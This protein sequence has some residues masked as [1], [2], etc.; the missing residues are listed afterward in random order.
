MTNTLWTPQNPEQTLLMDYMKSV[1]KDDMTYPE[2]WSWSCEH[3]DE[4]WS[5]LWDFCDVIGDKGSRVLVE[6]NH[7]RDAQFFPDASI[8]YAENCLKRRYTSDVVVF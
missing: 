6:G 4:F 3:S 2:L 1:G 8:N 5:S 7:I